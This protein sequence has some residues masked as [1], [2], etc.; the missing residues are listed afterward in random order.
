MSP[1]LLAVGQG[2]LPSGYTRVMAGVLEQLRR[3]FEV[4]LFAIDA[5]GGRPPGRPYA[6]RDNTAG[7]L[8]GRVELPG[9]LMDA[10]PDVVLFQHDPDLYCVNRP[11]LDAYRA[12]RP[13]ARVVVYAPVNEETAPRLA[14]ADLAVLYTRHARQAVERA[15]PDP[16]RLAVIPHAVDTGRFHP[17]GRAEARRRLFPDRPELERAFVVLNANRNIHRKRIDLTLRGFARFAAGRPDAYLYLHMGARDAGADVHALAAE[18]G[19]AGRVLMTPYEGRRPAVGDE[20]L[21]LVYNAC[22]VGVSTAAA[23]GWGLVAFEHGA[24]G[25][26]QVLPDHGAFRELWQDSALLVPAADANGAG[27]L[28][29]PAAVAAALAR[30]HGDA[31]ERARLGARAAELARSPELGWPAVGERWR[32]LLRRLP[33]LPCGACHSSSRAAQRARATGSTRPRSRASWSPPSG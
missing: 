31:A 3:E 6:V 20:R 10:E 26:A 11:A 21:N 9:V 24:T 29:D 13:G 16:P 2:A 14:G 18:L 25:A 12:R 1:R 7:D 19:I 8:H 27:H 5:C 28:V 33:G 22:D 32:E 17:V 23:E 15:L 30:L 4:T